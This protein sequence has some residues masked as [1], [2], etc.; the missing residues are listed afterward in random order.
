MK[1]LQKTL[2]GEHQGELKI[3]DV[4]MLTSSALTLF[5]LVTIRLKYHLLTC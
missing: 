5:V 3:S 1:N 4:N 2:F